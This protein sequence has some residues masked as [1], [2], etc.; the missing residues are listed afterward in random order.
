VIYEIKDM[1]RADIAFTDEILWAKTTFTTSFER[2]TGHRF[3]EIILSS[4]T[5]LD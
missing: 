5:Q 4:G 3:V 1:P 2:Y